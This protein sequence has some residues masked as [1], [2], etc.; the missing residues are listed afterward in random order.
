MS[1]EKGIP[2][3]YLRKKNTIKLKIVILKEREDVGV[4]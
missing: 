3:I 4:L 1:K 2:I